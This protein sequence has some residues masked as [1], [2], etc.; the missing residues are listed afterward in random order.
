MDDVGGESGMVGDDK[1]E[2][3]EAEVDVDDAVFVLN[4]RS[5]F[6]LLLLPLF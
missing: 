4:T 5:L 2:T 1:A 3:A 6:F